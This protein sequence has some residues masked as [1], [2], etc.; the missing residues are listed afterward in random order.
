M[1]LKIGFVYGAYE[2]L[3]IEYL[4]SIL[5][6]NIPDIEIKLFYHPFLFS[7]ALLE[8]NFLSSFFNEKKHIVNKIIKFSPDI[9]AFSSMTDTFDFDF[10]I[11]TEIKRINPDITTLFG[12]IHP[13][14]AP[15]FVS[16]LKSIDFICIGEGE[17]AFLEF[18]N[19]FISNNDLNNI[20]NIYSQNTIT[21]KPVLRELVYDLSA[22][23]FPDKDLFYCI[24]P[25]FK[26]SYSIITSRG[27]FFKCSFCNNN[28]YS[29][30]YGSAYDGIRRRSIENVISE[31]LYAKKKWSPK[32]VVFEDDMFISDRKWTLKF[33]ERYEKEIALPYQCIGHPAFLDDELC[34]A[35]KKS[36]CRNI[37]I[38]V[39]SLENSVCKLFNRPQNHKKIINNIKLL[40][41]HNISFNIDHIGGAPG[42]SKA[43]QLK[44][45]ELYNELSPNRITYFFLTYYPGTEITEYALKNRIISIDEFNNLIKGKSSSYEQSGSVKDPDYENLRLLSGLISILPKRIISWLIKSG[46]YK[47][48]GK[49]YL[50]AKYL[51]SLITTLRN[52]EVRGNIIIKKYIYELLHFWRWI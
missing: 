34:I 42:E 24:A 27:C 50:F 29:K 49:S 1:K 5:K 18:C 41:K 52:R 11:A 35:L 43:M 40:K 48:L 17:F 14:A 23:P 20:K 3:G 19:A 2:S 51:P 6:H 37:E 44:A 45:I 36:G 31:L 33:L 8:N 38:G 32:S 15:E 12:G 46:N 7:D 22:L 30:Y 10:S 13:T 4:S 16:N 47:K 39:Q 26:E 28:L 9:L 25:Y 21:N